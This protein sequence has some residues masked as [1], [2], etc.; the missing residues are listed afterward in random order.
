MQR[1][2]AP[3][4]SHGTDFDDNMKALLT[5]SFQASQTLKQQQKVEEASRSE[6]ESGNVGYVVVLMMILI[7]L[8]VISITSGSSKENNSN[9]SISNNTKP[10]V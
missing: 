8:V 3:G 9:N 2:H 6:V 4:R 7:V 10:S 5:R 1:S